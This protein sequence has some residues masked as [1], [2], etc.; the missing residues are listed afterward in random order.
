VYR[1]LSYCPDNNK[2]GCTSPICCFSSTERERERER[3]RGGGGGIM[4][5]RGKDEFSVFLYGSEKH[6]PQIK[7]LT[8]SQP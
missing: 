2:M 1:T 5:T 4:P 3:E 6:C 7:P 8:L